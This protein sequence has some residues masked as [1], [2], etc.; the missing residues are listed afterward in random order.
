MIKCNYLVSN[1]AKRSLLCEVALTPKPGLVDL[2][3]NGS[4]I[5]MNI[6]TFVDSCSALAPF[7][8]RYYFAGLS[9]HGSPKQLF[10]KVREIGK[11]AETAMLEATHGVNTHKGANFSFALLLSATGF[12]EQKGV[13]LP[14]HSTDTQQ[15]LAYVADMTTSLVEADLKTINTQEKTALSYGERLYVEQGITGI[16]GEAATG[17]PN[18]QQ[19]ALPFLRAH[20]GL[21]QNE[22][23]LRLLLELMSQVEDNNI[24]HRGGYIA[25]EKVQA[26]SSNLCRQQVSFNEFR[27]LVYHLDKDMI[28]MNLS[29]GG[30]ADLLSLAIFLSFLEKII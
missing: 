3:N 30:C 11:N 16:R 29:P 5:D 13:Q 20:K 7:F 10:E 23:F 4:H 6:Y 22:L 18:L 26:M 25:L 28:Q 14:F 8:D 27:K 9:H 24:L 17:Y 21:S 15:L 12:M 19:L 2:K 1:F